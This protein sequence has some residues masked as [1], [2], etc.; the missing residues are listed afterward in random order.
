MI[1]NSLIYFCAVILPWLIV[2]GLIVY[3][4][5]SKKKV[6]NLRLLGL[7][8][9]SAILAWFL[10]SLFKYNFPSL[11]PFE[12]YNNLEPLFV[13]GKGDAFPS[14]HATFMGALALGVFLQKRKLGL[15]FIL[16]AILV[17]LARVLAHVHSSLDVIVGLLFGALVAVIVLVIYYKRYPR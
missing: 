7:S 10:A 1:F 17:A 14:G 8:F 12:I 2:I 9:F 4:L 5:F 13:T 6:A 11:R 16:G 3:F 15:I